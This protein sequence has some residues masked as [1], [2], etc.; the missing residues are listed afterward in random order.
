MQ[1]EKDR[2]TDMIRES[3]RSEHESEEERE[4]MRKRDI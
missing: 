1:K 2:H 4:H 3:L